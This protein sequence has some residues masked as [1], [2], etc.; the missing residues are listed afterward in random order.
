[1]PSVAGQNFSMILT[2]KVPNTTIAEFSNN[3]DHNELSLLDLQCLP[4]SLYNMMQFRLKLFVLLLLCVCVFF[5]I[6]QT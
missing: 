6:F 4:S 5:F 1:M 3:V 2:L